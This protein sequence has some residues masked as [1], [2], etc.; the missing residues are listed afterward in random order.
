MLTP[1]LCQVSNLQKRRL[2]EKETR[3][4]EEV[5][6][7]RLLILVRPRENRHAGCIAMEKIPFSDGTDLAL[8]KK[9]GDRNV[10]HPF[11]HHCA[12][13]MGLPEEAF[14]ATAAAEQ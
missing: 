2:R 6:S 7:P 11:L 1:Y 14:P 3:A 4:L 8:G 13:M 10:T 12:V 9:P 5:Q